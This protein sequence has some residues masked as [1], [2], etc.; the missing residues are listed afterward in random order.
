MPPYHYL[1]YLGLILVGFLVGIVF[2]RSNKDIFPVIVLLGVTFS[3]EILSKYLAY[4]IQNNSPVYHVYHPLQILLW[5]V[6]FYRNSKHNWRV[7]IRASSVGLVT[8]SIINALFWQSFTTFPS[9]VIKFE[10]ILLL[11]WSFLLFFEFLDAPNNLN[12]FRNSSFL[13]CIAVIW[14]NLVSYLFFGLFNYYIS[15]PKPEFS[16]RTIHLFSNYTY[17]SILLVS[18]CIRPSKPS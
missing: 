14:F 16:I 11:A 6:F 1:I 13:I 18:M 5:G 17:Y 2:H 7:Y 4:T 9:N 3:S 10:C 8:F 12:I 15:K